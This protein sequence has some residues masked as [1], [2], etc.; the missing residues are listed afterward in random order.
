M[1]LLSDAGKDGWLTSTRSVPPHLK[2]LAS[3]GKSWMGIVASRQALLDTHPPLRDFDFAV[4][5]PIG[6]LGLP[7]SAVWDMGSHL[8]IRTQRGVLQLW[9]QPMP[10]ASSGEVTASLA[11]EFMRDSGIIQNAMGMAGV[12]AFAP[13]STWEP[14]PRPPVPVKVSVPLTPRIPLNRMRGWVVPNPKRP[15]FVQ[16]G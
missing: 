2:T 14:S 8:A 15:S 1:D 3:Q 10:F 9:K 11:G 6:V 13:E 4:P 7:T 16:R 5:N 12:L